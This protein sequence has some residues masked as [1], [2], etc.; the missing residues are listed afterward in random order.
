M[1]NILPNL[2]AMNNAINLINQSS[3]N[4]KFYDDLA[5]KQ[6]EDE[7]R[8]LQRRKE[9]Q[10]RIHREYEKRQRLEERRN[11]VIEVAPVYTDDEKLQIEK[12]LEEWSAERI[13][14]QVNN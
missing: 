4:R 6:R 5:K 10:E 1:I 2:I 7:K 11:T 13:G 14:K 9:E 8:L 12:M 3:R